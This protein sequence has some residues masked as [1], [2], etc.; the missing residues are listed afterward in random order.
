MRLAKSN[1]CRII[2]IKTNGDVTNHSATTGFADTGGVF[3]TYQQCVAVD[4]AA[5]G[6]AATGDCIIFELCEASNCLVGFNG[7]GGGNRMNSVNYCAALT[8]GTGFKGGPT[9]I[10]WCIATGCTAGFAP[11]NDSALHNCVAYATTTSGTTGFAVTV[12]SYLYSCHAQGAAIG[13][14]VQPLTYLNKCSG[15]G[16]TANTAGSPV[17]NVNFQSLSGDPFTN[18]AGNDFSTNSTA[19]AGALLRAAGNPASWTGLSTTSYPDIGAAQ[20]ASAAGGAFK[21]AGPGGGLVG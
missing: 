4:A 3:V 16:N 1:G 14:D 6:F 15:F 7:L 20:S 5:D 11:N 17:R 12:R 2:N 21:H 10:H 13:F 19:G 8:C 9:T 18:A